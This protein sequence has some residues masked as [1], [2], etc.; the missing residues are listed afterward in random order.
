MR[1]MTEVLSPIALIVLMTAA[2]AAAIDKDGLSTEAMTTASLIDTVECTATLSYATGQQTV[3]KIAC[4][5]GKYFFD[6]TDVVA[7][8][9]GA[10]N[11]VMAYNGEQSQELRGS[12][13][14]VTSERQ[15]P[16]ILQPVLQP[17]NWIFTTT[18]QE[19]ALDLLRKSELWATCFQ[20]AVFR[21]DG[22][23][24]SEE[25][26]VL[27]FAQSIPRANTTV[28]Y[29]VYFAK[30]LASYPLKYE[31]YVASNNQLSTRCEVVQ[32]QVI[33][34]DGRK[35]VFP[36]KMEYEELGTDGSSR[37][38]RI[39]ITTEPSSLKINQPIDDDIFTLSPLRAKTVFDTERVAKELRA[40]SVDPQQQSMGIRLPLLILSGVLVGSI[41]LVLVFRWSR[42][43]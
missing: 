24:G 38:C 21:G 23:A 15:R 6:H 43:R 37:P 11:Y 25:C 3:L 17:F 5:G 4:K 27:E 8:P 2:N 28:L 39:T 9:E 7:P 14:R 35:G 36:L 13:L 12:L 34:S 30:R 40:G 18:G 10:F 26:N 42:Q 31:R 29:R 32:Y 22:L 16:L 41:V 20:A 19:P 33:D 1:S